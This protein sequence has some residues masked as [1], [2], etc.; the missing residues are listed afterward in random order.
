M[1]EPEKA[2]CLLTDFGDYDP[3]HLAWLHN[4]ASLHAV[5]SWFNRIRRRSAMLERPIASS[6]NCGRVWNGI[7]PTVR[8]RSASWSKSRALRPSKQT[9]PVVTGPD[10]A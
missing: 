7:L 6:A 8:S 10:W 3:D 1:A 9:G 4:K 5:D 2:S